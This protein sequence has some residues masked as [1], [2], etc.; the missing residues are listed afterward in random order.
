MKF[1]KTL[2]L[3]SISIISCQK[4]I[5]IDRDIV[6]PKLVI[7]C[8]LSPFEDTVKLS[9]TE[10]RDLLYDKNTFP[11][12]SDAT[13]ELFENDIKIGELALFG[14]IYI[15]P[16]TV[17]PG[18]KYAIKASS[19]GFVDVDAETTVSAPFSN[20]DFNIEMLE[21]NGWNAELIIEDAKNED[22][23]F[24]VRFMYG[25]FTEDTAIIN[26]Q[27]YYPP[28][29]N[30]Y[31]CTNDYIIE[32]PQSELLSSSNCAGS[33]LFSDK[34]FKNSNHT[35]RM[36][37]EPNSNSFFEPGEGYKTRAVIEYSSY[38]YDYFTYSV[39]KSIY[40][41]NQGNPF[42]EPVSVYSNITNGYGIFGSASVHSDTLIFE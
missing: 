27:F 9:L 40:L 23:F 8:V 12:V 7:N 36:F 4:A 20:L 6:Q 41:N 21:N 26:S 33:F 11:V 15:L 13:I 5:E 19:D 28:W 2:A 31:F 32:H 29:M 35:L 17:K 10:S 42:A 39:T 37:V 3:I 14:E 24:E 34:T 25:Y 38:N 1:I 18:A 30:G 22:N 16:Y